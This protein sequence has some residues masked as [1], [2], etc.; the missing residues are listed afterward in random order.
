MNGPA[1]FLMTMSCAS[2]EMTKNTNVR[3]FACVGDV[4]YVHA[5]CAYILIC[6]DCR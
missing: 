6:F 2:A 5:R 3:M 1:F 4:G